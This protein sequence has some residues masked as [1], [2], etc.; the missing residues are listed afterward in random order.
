MQTSR[1]I[2][3]PLIAVIVLSMACSVA[4]PGSGPEGAASSGDGTPVAPSSESQATPGAGPAP[5]IDQEALG[6]ASLDELLEAKI[7]HEGWSQEQ[8]LLTGLSILA[9]Q[10]DVT[11]V[12]GKTPFDGEG[13]GVLAQAA[14]YLQAGGDAATR[15]ELEHLLGI[16]APPP[17]RLLEAARPAGTQASRPPGLASPASGAAE[18]AKIF[19]EG[20]PSGSGTICLEYKE[21]D[22]GAWKGRVFYPNWWTPA[23]PQWPYLEAAH[24]AMADSWNLYSLY[25]EMRAIDLVFTVLGNQSHPTT[26]AI[27]PGVGGGQSCQIAVYPAAIQIDAKKNGA[28]GPSIPQGVFK[29]IIAHEMFHCFQAV[30]FPQHAWDVADWKAVNDWWGESTAEYFS[31]L[32]YPTINYEWRWR[33]AFALGSIENSIFDMSYANFAWF[34]YLGNQ[35]AIGPQGIIAI[36]DSLPPKSLIHQHEAFAKVAGVGGLWH[37][38]GQ[39]VLD[40]SVDDSGGSEIA[41]PDEWTATIPILKSET[42]SLPTRE[43]VLT[44]YRLA[45]GGGTG[46]YLSVADA[47]ASVTSAQRP[48]KSGTW[49]PFP[50]DQAMGCAQLAAL[51]TS[52][53][54]KL[55]P[56]KFDLQVKIDQ[57]PAPGSACDACVVGRWRMTDTSYMN[58]YNAVMSESEGSGSFS[59]LASG[60]LILDVH[61]DGTLDALADS[62]TTTVIGGMLDSQNQAVET[63]TKLTLDGT[64]AMSYLAL[65]GI[66]AMQVVKQGISTEVTFTI[67][68]AEFESDMGDIMPGGGF[69]SGGEGSTTP[70]AYTCDSAYLTLAPLVHAELYKGNV[71]DFARQQP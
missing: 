51:V 63:E 70:F 10:Q 47:G 8:A 65:D 22:L 4:V 29:Q 53:G 35:A 55:T 62:F 32:V 18:C 66:L 38:F 33:P 34:Q 12:L 21:Q 9:G 25:G 5:E 71:W 49:A 50:H 1:R 30:H 56:L 37:D 19:E 14:Y 60:D 28:Y 69:W 31:N 39:A 45:L 54:D 6:P 24:Q 36:I 26:L 13:T 3:V 52:G 46:F 67:G 7:Q 48:V 27:A 15:A 43:F 20:F 44:R 23:D 59:A 16:V 2:A 42:L 68:D 41:F 61:D 11:A 17:E 64:T 57:P 58:M 40:D